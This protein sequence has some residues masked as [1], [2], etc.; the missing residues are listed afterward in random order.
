MRER[1]E[2]RDD[3]GVIQKVGRKM[4]RIHR[5]SAIND[6]FPRCKRYCALVASLGARR[7]A[8]AP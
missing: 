6:E 3:R 5:S 4:R 1:R 8:M 7:S 2:T